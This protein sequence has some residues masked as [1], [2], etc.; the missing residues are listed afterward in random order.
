MSVGVGMGNAQPAAWQNRTEQEPQPEPQPPPLTRFWRFGRGH[1]HQTRIGEGH[2][3][4]GAYVL[5]YNH[6]V[7]GVYLELALGG[8]WPARP[9][10]PWASLV[11]VRA[12]E[13]VV[14]WEAR[15][16]DGGGPVIGWGPDTHEV[17]R[18]WEEER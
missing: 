14:R 7:L 9:P 4:R 2:G 3:G 18:L 17:L 15:W 13:I 8:R 6:I 1:T 11:V 5:F 10:W 16:N 12:Q